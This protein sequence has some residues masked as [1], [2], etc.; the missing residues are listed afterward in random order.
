[1]TVENPNVIDFVAHEPSGEVVLVMVEGRNWDGSEERLFELQEKINSYASYAFDGQMLEEHPELA[2]KP[3]RLELRCAG[4]P[5]T[6][7]AK[8][9]EMV[10]ERLK[11]EGLGFSVKEIG[12]TSSG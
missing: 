11:D 1:M 7:T 6:G 4:A 3:V 10:R 9:L 5:D 2:G 8:F 12:T